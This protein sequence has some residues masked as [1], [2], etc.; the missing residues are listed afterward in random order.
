MIQSTCETS[1]KSPEL[2]NRNANDSTSL[3]VCF[4][5]DATDK[6][7]IHKRQA[8]LAG[9]VGTALLVSSVALYSSF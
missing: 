9:F 3:A 5:S 2:L 7:T 4:D 6:K 1:K 8:I